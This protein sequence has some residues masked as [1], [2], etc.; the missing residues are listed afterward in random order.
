MFDVIDIRVVDILNVLN[1]NIRNSKRLVENGFLK[2]FN[3]FFD[4][5]RDFA[6]FLRNR[7]YGRSA[8]RERVS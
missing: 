8:G 6:R 4:F 2:R 7:I 3:R 5:L 1:F